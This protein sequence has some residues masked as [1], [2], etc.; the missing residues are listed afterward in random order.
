MKARLL[1]LPALLILASALALPKSIAQREVPARETP[2]N[3]AQVRNQIV[4]N[5][6][7][8]KIK[9]HAVAATIVPIV[10]DK[11]SILPHL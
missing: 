1:L 2:K 11:Q 7:A 10:T 6:P 9:K 4:I 5:S 3:A 8:V